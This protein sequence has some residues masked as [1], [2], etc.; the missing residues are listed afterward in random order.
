MNPILDTTATPIPFERIRAEHILPAVR[1]AVVAAEAELERVLATEPT[2]YA[3]TLAVLDQSVERIGRVVS[4]ASHLNS[5]VQDEAIRAAWGEATPV[6]SA[7]FARLGTSAELLEL[8]EAVLETDR[9]MSD[10]ERRH[11]ELTR[12]ELR[13]SGAHLDPSTRERLQALQVRLAELMRDFADNVLDATNEFRLHLTD[14]A[15]LDGLPP[16]FVAQAR[17]EA[18]REGVEGWIVTL[19]P[20]S[21]RPF[22]QHSTRRELRETVHTAKAHLASAPPHDNR[23][24]VQRILET[25]QEIAGLLGEPTWADHALADSMAGSSEVARDFVA[26]LTR[27]TRPYRDAEVE[28]LEGLARELGLGEIRPWDVLHLIEQHRVRTC[29]I[30]DERLRPWFE[31]GSV[32]DGMFGLAERL[33]G[34]RVEPAE[35]PVWHPE[36][37]AFTIRQGGLAVAQLYT[38]WFPRPSKRGGAWM[39]GIRHGVPTADGGFEPHVAVICGN[40]TPPDEAG[41]SL[42]THDEVQTLFHEFGHALHH[43]LSTVPVRAL[44][45]T[46]VYTDWVEV[47]SQLMEN[48]VWE[49][50]ALDGFARHVETGK[51]IP[52]ALFERLQSTR[53]HLGGYAQ[54]RQLG[55]AS[56]DLALHG[57]PAAPTFEA[58]LRRA[59]KAGEPYQVRPEFAHDHLITAFTHL[60]SSG[61]AAKYYSYKWSEAHEA[62]LF[63]RFLEDGLLNEELGHE[64]ARTILSRGNA[65]EPADMFRAFMGRD[66]DPGA[67]I[68]RNLGEPAAADRTGT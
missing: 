55:F 19:H 5:V 59:W 51:P 52:D 15:D 16:S 24:P 32:M 48:W 31:L 61:Y 45:G 20:P 47:P 11:A 65:E 50:A 53:T 9:S 12:R 26:D 29:D 21:M 3:T 10:V 22:L 64:L 2:T 43:C 41:R 39:H 57:E 46:Q 42:L 36:V 33:F 13:Q 23:G 28:M 38:D 4:L 44:S 49:R 56:L 30:D 54:M 37:R 66:L 34:I 8:T 1:E 17:R 68:R 63:G 35:L 58:T 18:E 40:F 62:D 6:Y 25:R 14:P 27:R 67:L 60:F 7:Y